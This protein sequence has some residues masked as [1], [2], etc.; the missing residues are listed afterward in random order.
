MAVDIKNNPL[1]EKLSVT[2]RKKM[3]ILFFFLKMLTVKFWQKVMALIW[4]WIASQSS[5]EA[6]PKLLKK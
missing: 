6:K 1:I 3:K 4:Y 2:A 5:K